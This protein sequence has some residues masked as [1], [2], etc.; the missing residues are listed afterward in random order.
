V[1]TISGRETLFVVNHFKVKNGGIVNTHAFTLE[2]KHQET[3]EEMLETVLNHIRAEDPAFASLVVTNRDLP[4]AD[5]PEG[6]RLE[7]PKIGDKRKLVELSLKNGF[8]LLREKANVGRT[9]S[10]DDKHAKLMETMQRDLRLVHPPEHIECFDNSNIQGYE[11]VSSCVVF[12]GGKPSKK[13]Y[14]HFRVKTVQGPD[15]FAT[16]REVVQRRYRGVLE[17]GEP[18]PDLIVIDGGKGQ[19][20]HACEALAELGLA[21]QVP[22]I[23]IAKRLEEIY[24]M[25]DPVPLYIDKKSPTLKVIQQ[26]RNEAHRFAITYHRKRRDM[27]TLRTELTEI[28]GI[29]EKLA[30]LLLKE[31]G[32]VEGVRRAAPDALAQLVGP[33]KAEVLANWAWG[34]PAAPPPGPSPEPP[35]E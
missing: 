35:A 21:R 20:S 28:P 12:K 13:D 32:S 10:W 18:L 22:I 24:Y 17:R 11:P 4:E 8:E 1:L 7:V 34:A 19:L 25:N 31:F 16:M 2:P 23:G 26:I 15:D 14:R 5:L 33:K 27:A 30:V 9:K 3:P 29:G 6:L